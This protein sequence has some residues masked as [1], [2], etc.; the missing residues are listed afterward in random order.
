MWLLQRTY[1]TIMRQLNLADGLTAKLKLPPNKINLILL[2]AI[3]IWQ[4]ANFCPSTKFICIV[5]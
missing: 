4:L 3:L 1:I 2:V 5:I